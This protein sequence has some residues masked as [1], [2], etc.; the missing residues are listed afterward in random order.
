MGT[1]ITNTGEP[2]MPSVDE[3][4]FAIRSQFREAEERGLPHLEINSGQ[5][6]RKL[7]G[8]PGPK[9]QMPSCWRAM[10]NEQQAGD[11]IIFRPPKGNGASL[12]ICYRLPRSEIAVHTRVKMTVA[13]APQPER[14]VVNVVSPA[15]GRGSGCRLHLASYGFDFICEI[16]PEKNSDGSV[17]QFMPQYRYENFANLPLNKYGLG[18]FC[19]FQ[20]PDNNESRGVYIV[21]IHGKVQYVGEC[22][23]LSS[24]F[25]MGYGNISPRNC[26][27]GGQETNCRLNNLVY[28]ATAADET[29]LLWFY[30][31]MD[32][33]K[34]EA[35]LR[36]TLMAPWN[37]V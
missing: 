29:I 35:E 24:R 8:Y 1:V 10:Y 3:F 19:K 31:T 6:H 4:R 9:A 16:K 7:G 17:T 5:L 37:R 28:R 36:R 27:K 13:K 15:I 32:N 26:F 20:I 22:E 23:N 12:T 33:K 11:E 30:H 14:S 25:N 21:T 18:P 2:D 34:V